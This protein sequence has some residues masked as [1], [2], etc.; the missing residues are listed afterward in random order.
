M[1][2]I[3]DDEEETPAEPQEILV[4]ATVP[5]I[6]V[7]LGKQQHFVKLPNFLSVETR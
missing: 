3:A 4:E 5:H 2:V 7:G 6:K 1:P